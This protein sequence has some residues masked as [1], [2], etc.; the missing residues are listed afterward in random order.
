MDPDAWAAIA[1]A[2]I[3]D[4][5]SEEARADVLKQ[6]VTSLLTPV[7]ESNAFG[8]KKKTPLQKAFED[9]INQAAYKAVH[10]KVANDV[11]VRTGINALLGPLIN[12]ALQAEAENYNDDL[13]KAIGEA[14]GT[15]LAAQARKGE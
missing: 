10:D 2:A 11:Q 14:V 5:M 9:A 3:F 12:G 6:A 13:A 1:S 4:Q 15:W 7:E 8:R